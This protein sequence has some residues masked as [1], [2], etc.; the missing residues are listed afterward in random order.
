MLPIYVT[1]QFRTGSYKYYVVSCT[2]MS[3]AERVERYLKVQGDLDPDTIEKTK[4][5][6]QGTTWVVS[7]EETLAQYF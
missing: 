6:P 5:I 2:S 1:A 3:Q 7:F 4:R